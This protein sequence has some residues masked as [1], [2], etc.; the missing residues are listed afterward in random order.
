MSKPCQKNVKTLSK[1]CQ[2]KVIGLVYH[3]QGV[4]GLA[5]RVGRSPPPPENSPG[6]KPPVSFF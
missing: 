3:P 6:V 5:Y 2:K 4:T 1:E